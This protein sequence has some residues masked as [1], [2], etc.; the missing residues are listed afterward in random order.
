MSNNTAVLTTPV[1]KKPLN[2]D[3]SLPANIKDKS[4]EELLATMW[5][6]DQNTVQQVT[7]MNKIYSSKHGMFASI[8]IL[9]RGADCV[10]SD[11]CL[12]NKAQRIVGNRCPQEISVI[13]TRFNM[14]CNYFDIDISE[15][16]IPDKYLVDATLVKD[17]VN[18]EI[19]QLRAENKM[20]I[21]GDFMETTIIDIDNKCKPY[22]GS[23]ISP[24]S[25]YLMTLYDKKIKIL[26]QLNAT[27]K[28]KAVDRRNE[29]VSDEAIRIFQ[30]MQ[31]MKK[32]QDTVQQDIMDVEFDED[33]NIIQEDNNTNNKEGESDGNEKHK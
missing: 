31:E 1:N 33:G 24:V 13:I 19:L 9:C 28:D 12:V 22:Y 17:L 26:N 4:G 6:M 21:S 20:A 25:D 2:K 3:S 32:K 29:N 10:Y 30:Q 27:R 7:N 14:W 8:P 11:T 5:G 18:T 15:E 23:V 16:I